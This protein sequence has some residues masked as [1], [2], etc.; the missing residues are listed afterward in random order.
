[1]S[2]A[3]ETDDV[4][5]LLAKVAEILSTYFTRFLNKRMVGTDTA[6]AEELARCV[7]ALQEVC[8]RGE[9]ILRLTDDFVAGSVDEQRVVAYEKLLEQQIQEIEALRGG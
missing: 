5:T 3:K 2:S 6:V 7:T 9:A 4:F 1:M 8:V